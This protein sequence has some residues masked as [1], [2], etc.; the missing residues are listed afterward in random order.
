M[1]SG[2]LD[3][4]QW[5][6]ESDIMTDSYTIVE[7]VSI[8]FNANH[9]HILTWLDTK[10]TLQ[11]LS[12]D[13]L[14]EAVQS[15]HLPVVIWFSDR[16]PDAFPIGSDCEG[17]LYPVIGTTDARMAMWL[18]EHKGL[19]LEQR[20]LPQFALL[21]DVALFEAF[22][23]QLVDKELLARC[24]TFVFEA[25]CNSGSVAMM[26]HLAETYGFWTASD[27]KTA[28]GYRHFP[29][30]SW[31]LL[32]SYDISKIDRRLVLMLICADEWELLERFCARG[33]VNCHLNL[34]VGAQL[35]HNSDKASKVEDYPHFLWGDRDDDYVWMRPLIPLTLTYAPTILNR[36]WL[37]SWAARYNYTEVLWRLVALEYQWIFSNANFERVLRHTR[38]GN[39][40]QLFLERWPEL[41]DVRVVRWAAKYDLRELVIFVLIH[42]EQS[43][44]K[45]LSH[46]VEVVIS[47]ASRYGHLGLLQWLIKLVAGADADAGDGI[48]T[49]EAR[50]YDPWTSATCGQVHILQW[51][52]DNS[53]LDESKL[54][55]AIQACV[56][57]GQ[58]SSLYWW[59]THY[60]H[61]CGVHRPNFSLR[62]LHRAVGREH[63]DVVEWILSKQPELKYENPDV[64]RQVDAL[65]RKWRALLV[66]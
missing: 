46:S 15:G 64:K 27:V 52:H 11:P 55:R 9:V 25:A 48:V 57:R 40:V 19:R 20:L 24:R 4:T 51:L 39:L 32:T 1:T 43:G 29:L 34:D 17:L 42:A 53:L 60:N 10:F 30:A 14:R 61:N 47:T 58:L 12:F 16:F 54:T 28:L 36:N 21:G 8:A 26:Q 33:Q 41:L 23:T 45:S 35:A 31:M 65:L 66:G 37:F 56:G 6:I 63:V 62:D 38:D 18:H 50:K 22:L 59:W 7:L 44:R 2:H 13:Q 49:A 3:T 5:L